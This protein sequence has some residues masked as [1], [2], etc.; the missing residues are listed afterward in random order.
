[1][2]KVHERDSQHE[3]AARGSMSCDSGRA[4]RDE[5]LAKLATLCASLNS[6]ALCGGGGGYVAGCCC[7]CCANTGDWMGAGEARARTVSDAGSPGFGSSSLSREDTEDERVGPK[8][9]LVD[10]VAV[11]AGVGAASKS[12]SAIALCGSGSCCRSSNTG[13]GSNGCCSS[14]KWLAMDRVAT[15][16]SGDLGS[17]DAGGGGGLGGADESE[18]ES[19]EAVSPSSVAA[20]ESA[21]LRL[22]CIFCSCSCSAVDDIVQRLSSQRVIHITGL[23]ANRPSRLTITPVYS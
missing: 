2:M 7:C 19:W 21:D 14:S 15:T 23:S 16:A 5:L 17:G 11:V 8:S 4:L 3:R 13:S 18:M 20:C 9:L 22:A 12:T 10:V 6:V 1:M